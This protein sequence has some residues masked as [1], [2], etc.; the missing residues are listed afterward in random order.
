VIYSIV[1]PLKDEAD[2][3]EDL[4]HEIEPVMQKVTG[5]FQDMW[6]MICVD[7]GSSDATLTVLK[8]LA[9]DKPFLKIVALD[10]NY[11]QSLA[12]DAGFKK[13]KGKWII[14]LDGD[15]QNDPQDIPHLLA[16]KD[17]F[18]LV[19]G[20]REKRQ[21][22][23]HKKIISKLANSVRKRVCQDNMKD[24]G[25]S[26]KVYR[27]SCLSHIKM[28][29]GM[30]RFL[31]ALFKIEGFTVTEVFVNHRPRVKGKTKYNIF[32]RCN[33]IIDMF[34]VWWMSKRRVD[35]KIKNL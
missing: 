2:N 20:Y 30:H 34:A 27:A 21:D 8:K 9:K 28:Y 35:Y 23:W 1:V 29:K 4:I 24:T 13:A 14:T 15:R 12:F 17:E 6:E 5:N 19:A 32:N 10:K 3:I 11:G 16:F 22:P 26:L 7:D 31:P 33:T 18:D 25:C